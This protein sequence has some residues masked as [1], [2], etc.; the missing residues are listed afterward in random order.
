MLVYRS[1]LRSSIHL[2]L[3][4]TGHFCPWSHPSINL[5]CLTTSD[6]QVTSHVSVSNRHR[7]QT[8]PVHVKPEPTVP[9]IVEDALTS[10]PFR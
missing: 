2:D 5:E 10:Q 8:L 6:L 4:H 3:R 1:N 9:S 7:P